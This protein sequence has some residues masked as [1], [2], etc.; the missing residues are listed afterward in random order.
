MLL[1]RT[2]VRRRT[3]QAIVLVVALGAAPVLA[4]AVWPGAASVIPP[5][6]LVLVVAAS[7][8]LALLV[9]RTKW[10]VRILVPDP[11]S[12]ED[13]ARLEK[14]ARAQRASAAIGL[15]VAVFLIVL[16]IKSPL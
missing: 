11:L 13:V 8:F 6:L 12:P 5:P 3:A 9:W 15:M 1:P 7:A 2:L 4:R 16:W 10:L 14:T